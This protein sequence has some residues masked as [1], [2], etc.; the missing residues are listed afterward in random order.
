MRFVYPQGKRKALTFSYDDGQS[1]DGRLAELLR[2]H[3]MKGT[4]HLNSGRLGLR[5]GDEVYI[6]REE[7]KEVYAGHEVACHGVEHRNLPT[8]TRQQVILEIQEDRKVLEE[9]TGGLVQGM[10]YAFG[11][12]NQEIMDIARALGIK[13]SRT[14]QD[15]KN[16]F[17]PSDFMAW[18]PTCHHDNGLLE[19]A[20]SFIDV[21]GYYELPVMYVWGHSFEFGRTGDWSVIEAFV[22]KMAG[23][24][25][26]W[27]ATN[28]EI[29]TYIQAVRQQEFSADGL[30]M[31]NPTAVSVWVS[32]MQGVAEVK[33]LQSIKL[34]V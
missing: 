33:P 20:D 22:D 5:R 23:Q 14:I 7:V 26:I 25:N 28:M 2:S 10:S 12:Y 3:G 13:Y 19:L 18:H 24:E 1:F 11:N 32:T 9:V 4:F 34:A 17:P 29:Y 27:Y 16:F 21:A 31:Y 15:T 8:I 6:S 30:T